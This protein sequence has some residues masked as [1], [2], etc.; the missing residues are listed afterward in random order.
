[1][2]ANSCLPTVDD[3]AAAI[4]GAKI[5]CCW[6]RTAWAERR[7]REPWAKPNRASPNQPWHDVAIAQAEAVLVLMEAR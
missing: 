4:H 5:R 1:M 3:V 2:I 7:A 6:D